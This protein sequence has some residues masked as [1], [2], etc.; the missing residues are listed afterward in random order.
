MSK[1]L[2]Q[3]ENFEDINFKT[4]REFK[5]A[6][7]HGSEIQFEWNNKDYAITHPDGMIYVCEAYTEKNAKQYKTVDEAL[8][9][10]IDG[11]KLSE[12]ITKVQ[13]WDRTI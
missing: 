2:R 7:N 1:E 6:V 10:I 8:E 4:V 13:V 11:Q 9:Y 12:I 5:F 3:E